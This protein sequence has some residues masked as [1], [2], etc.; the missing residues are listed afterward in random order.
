M[1]TSNN[2]KTRTLGKSKKDN[3]ATLKN[4]KA[5]AEVNFPVIVWKVEQVFTNP[6][7]EFVELIY[8]FPT[9]HG[10]ILQ[11]ITV[12][13][14]EKRLLGQV[15]SAT[16]A[17][18]SYSDSIADGN[19][20]IL[21]EKNDFGLFTMNIGNLGPGETCQIHFESAALLDAVEGQAKIIFPTV[22]DTRY[23]DPS[24]Q[25]G[26]GIHAKPKNSWLVEYP[27]ELSVTLN[28]PPQQ[29][30]IS[31]ATHKIKVSHGAE[32]IIGLGEI[33]YLDR[34]FELTL[35]NIANKQSGFVFRD[36][37]SETEQFMSLSTFV[38]EEAKS[39][40]NHSNS[41][42]LKILVDCS[43][44]MQG[45]RIEQAKKALHGI[46]SSLN[47]D[48]KFTLSKFGDETY[49]FYNKPIKAGSASLKSAF[50]WIESLTA[51]LGGTELIDAVEEVSKL[52]DPGPSNVF[53]ITDGE[54]WDG[55]R[56]IKQ[57]KHYQIRLFVVAIGSSSNSNMLISAAKSSS[58]HVEIPH[59]DLHV[60]ESAL[61][62]YKR[63]NSP[64]AKLTSCTL[65]GNP[66]V[67][68]ETKL[69]I[70]KNQSIPV[71]SIQASLATESILTINIGDDKSSKDLELNSTLSEVLDP[72]LCETLARLCV[73]KALEELEAEYESMDSSTISSID[74]PTP[75]VGED[76]LEDLALSYQ[77]LSSRTK[78]LVTEER[79]I[80][81]D[82]LPKVVGVDHM[83]TTRLS[84]SIACMSKI[85]TS[86]LESISSPHQISDLSVPALFR[87]VRGNTQSLNETPKY[88]VG[89][90][91]TSRIELL[92]A[93]FK[94]DSFLRKVF[95]D[96]A[97]T[98]S[99][100][101]FSTPAFL[102]GF[103]EQYAIAEGVPQSLIDWAKSQ[104]NN[105]EK[106]RSVISAIFK[107]I[108][109]KREETML[110]H[111]QFQRGSWERKLAQ[112][113][114]YIE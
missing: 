104:T 97:A 12:Q 58:G 100:P 49:H 69:P 45:A 52:G 31:S 15:V 101:G 94:F 106:L 30:E 64:H 25:G 78:Y 16:Q 109:I 35:G 102:G 24:K 7:E 4:L 67:W 108:K 41:G 21:I 57:L 84:E 33:S 110:S 28:G 66:S 29:L 44:S 112:V 86:H 114:G 68:H 63:I 1:T 39:T 61:R 40:A 76:D 36:P 23:G 43:G 71:F 91:P 103:S 2:A 50:D 65:D 80:K 8:T 85:S 9:T 92:Y 75:W 17:D 59:S 34:D 42:P 98:Y 99:E 81:A 38:W 111:T 5:Q 48:H 54:I 74:S 88:E 93:K 10:S 56:F 60:E 22:I 19:S 27:L 82:G 77:L 72:S 55:K 37:F 20:A 113:L 96:F 51:D 3:V 14:G 26:L 70:F 13:L 73:S 62:L 87:S 32:L 89:T 107:L 47:P 90:Y 53:L 11:N 46:L 105:E 95:D 83:H 79:D 18:D 6:T